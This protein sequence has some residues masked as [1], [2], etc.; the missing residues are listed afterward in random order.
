MNDPNTPD[1]VDTTGSAVPPYEGRRAAA[2]PDEEPVR[3]GARVGGATGPASDDTTAAPEPAGTPGGVTASP[4]DE[5]PSS[6]APETDLDDD[7]VGPAHTAGTP[8]GED[9]S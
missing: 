2:G 4:A 9:R 5:Q 7:W 3:G 8:R 6:Q 1:G